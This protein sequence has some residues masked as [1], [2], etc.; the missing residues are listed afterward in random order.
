MRL[1]IL[2]RTF[3]QLEPVVGAPGDLVGGVDVQRLDHQALAVLLDRLL[4]SLLD[5]LRRLAVHGL[6]KLKLSLHG[7]EVLLQKLPPLQEGFSHQGLS[8]QV[9]KVESKEANLH[10][11]DWK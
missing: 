6:G 11:V 1:G 8:V 3:L 9:E 5:L 7:G 2:C 4:Q 10:L